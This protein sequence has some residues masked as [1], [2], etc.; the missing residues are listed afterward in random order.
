MQWSDLAERTQRE[1]PGKSTQDRDRERKARWTDVVDEGRSAEL[2]RKAHGGGCNDLG[3]SIRIEIRER[4]ESMP[5]P[6]APDFCPACR[7]ELWTC[8]P[9][10]TYLC[11]KD[12]ERVVKEEMKRKRRE[13]PNGRRQKMKRYYDGRRKG[14]EQE[15]EGEE[16]EKDEVARRRAVEGQGEQ[17]WDREEEEQEAARHEPMEDEAVQRQCWEE[18][19]RKNQDE[20][21]AR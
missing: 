10:A 5:C 4:S 17:D 19:D 7:Q 21:A 6:W 3:G 15:G 1:E 16:E 12:Y 11:S 20:E 13:K 14:Q 2:E 9:V 8:V 18:L